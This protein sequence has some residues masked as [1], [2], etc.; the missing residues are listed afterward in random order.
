[1]GVVRGWLS[2]FLGHLIIC[3]P[4]VAAMHMSDGRGSWLAF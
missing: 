1:M 4:P 2:D 3:R